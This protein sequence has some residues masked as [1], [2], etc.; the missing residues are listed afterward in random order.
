MTIAGI[1][2]CKKGWIAVVLEGKTVVDGKVFE[3][4]E[5]VVN[6]IRGV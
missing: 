5:A 2:G 3:N 6:G 1:D 4:F